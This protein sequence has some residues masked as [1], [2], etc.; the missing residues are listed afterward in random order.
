M[1]A[2][3]RRALIQ[4]LMLSQLMAAAALAQ[5]DP[6][7]KG[8]MDMEVLLAM[9]ITELSQLTVSTATRTNQAL[10]DAPATMVVITDRDIRERGYESLKDALRDLPGIDFVDVQGTFPLIW[11]PRGAYGDENKRTL[12]LIDGL[13]ENNILEGNVLGGP[14]YSL[15]NVQRIEVLWGPASALYGANAFSAVINLIPKKGRDIQGGQLQLGEGNF[16]THFQKFLLGDKRGDFEYSL[17]GSLHNSDGPVFKE[18]NPDYSL[19]YVDDAYSVA[20]DLGFKDYHLGFYRYD[21][22]MGHGQF[23]NPANAFFG[24]PLFGYNNSEGQIVNNSISPVDM[25]GQKGSLW[26]SV[27]NT[28]YLKGRQQARERLGFEE[29]IYYRATEI[30]DDSYDYTLITNAQNQPEWAFL[31]FT[32]YSR[33]L[34]GEW[35]ANLTLDDKQDLIAGISLEDSNVERGYRQWYIVQNSPRIW[36]IVDDRISINYRNRA[37]FGQYRLTTDQLGSTTYTLG[38][39]AD[40]NSVY[41]HTVNPR[42]GIVSKPY[43]TLT[44]KALYGSAYR[45]PN[46]FDSFTV[47][48]TRI[49]NPN[50]KPEKTRNLEFSAGYQA[51]AHWLLEASIFRNRLT[52]TIVSNVSIGD[53]DGDGDIETQN[54]NVGKATVEGVE[55]RNHVQ[56]SRH[57]S[58]FAAASYQDAEQTLLTASTPIPNVARWKGNAGLTWRPTADTTL[59]LAGRAVGKRSTAPT[60]PRQ[61]VDGYFVS[62]LNLTA[63]PFPDKQ[64]QLSLRLNNLFDSRYADPGVRVADGLS[65]STQHDYP[66][67]NGWLKLSYEF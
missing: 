20:G 18:R 48:T 9:P 19:S 52:D 7:A 40:D 17:S 28:V 6:P 53:I 39:R 42:L 13:V 30:A 57:V 21:R 15:H 50:L 11:A 45:A 3:V 35:L 58:L 47:T 46:S 33:L 65:F 32:H 10:Q 2:T 14:Q 56:L 61:K 67:R 64:V 63:R 43:D 27:T 66:G 60:N 38:L 4:G 23:A 55:L 37:A 16:H 54:R 36:G 29:K 12:L 51:S 26:H 41:G 44:L 62:D 22:P 34:G 8:D 24:L 1:P 49:A 31:P 25:N 59:Y 5:E